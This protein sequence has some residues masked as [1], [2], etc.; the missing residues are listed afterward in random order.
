MDYLKFTTGSVEV[1][2][3]GPGKAFY[4]HTVNAYQGGLFQNGI[5]EGF[6]STADARH[7]APVPE[8]T[9]ITINVMAHDS[10]SHVD[11]DVRNT[12]QND[13]RLTGSIISTVVN[14]RSRIGVAIIDIFCDNEQFTF[15]MDV[16]PTKI[17]YDDEYYEL[18]NDLQSISRELAFDWLR[19]SSLAGSRDDT[20]RSSDIEFLNA[21]DDELKRLKTN[22]TIIGHSPSRTIIRK[23]TVTRLD[24]LGAPTQQIIRTIAQGKGSGP[25]HDLNGVHVHERIP[26]TASIIGYDTPANRWLKQQLINTR[27]RIGNILRNSNQSL[28]AEDTNERLRDLYTEL[29][30]M[31]D[32]PF[33]HEVKNG[34]GLVKPNMEV[35]GRNGYRETARI[36]NDLDKAFTIAEGIQLVNSRLIAELYEEWCYLKVAMLVSH[37]TNGAIDPRQSIDVTNGNLRIRF[38]KNGR[39]RISITTNSNGEYSVAYNKEYKTLTGIQKPDIIIEI[40]TGHDNPTILVLDAKYRLT[41]HDDHDRTITPQPPV[42]AINALHR[43]RDAIYIDIQRKNMRI[44]PVV[45]CVIL[46]P[47]APQQDMN[48]LP[49]WDSIDQL[50]IGAIPLKPKNDGLLRQ[51]LSN[52]LDVNRPDFYKPGPSFEPY[53]S[54]LLQH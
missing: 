53:E 50:G 14:F 20:G 32:Q 40:N 17:G 15:T 37:I 35:L 48:D 33:L 54:I 4:P 25:I 2:V 51:Y 1:M 3:K 6:D 9:D 47:P 52:A 18:L 11:I 36:F 16:C 44:R 31:L 34:K 10:R 45:K 30:T 39:S 46:Y 8:Q 29:T 43:Y 13:N 23:D 41:D 12:K 28:Y 27:N 21:L 19:S 22:L 24:R 5:P 49:Y 7:P 42:D 38:S 26:A